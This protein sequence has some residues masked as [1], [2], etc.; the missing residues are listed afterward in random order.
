MV[1]LWIGFT[2]KVIK[3]LGKIKTWGFL[4]F[5]LECYSLLILVYSVY[6]PKKEVYLWVFLE[7]WEV[8]NLKHIGDSSAL[9]L[10]LD[11][12]VLHSGLKRKRLSN[13]Q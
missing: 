4:G 6:I 1:F 3:V 11:V 12:T 9:L 10:K 5:F 13:T 8:I 7:T 2:Q